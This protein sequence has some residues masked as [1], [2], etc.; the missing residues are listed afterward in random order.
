MDLPL[1]P[2]EL[3]LRFGGLAL[4]HAALI[5]SDLAEGELIC[6][7]AIVTKDDRR[8]VIPFEAESQVEAI[9]RGKASLEELRDQIDFWSLGREG[10]WSDSDSTSGKVDVLVISAWTHG[11]DA[12]ITLMQRFRPAAT[13]NFSLLGSVDIILEGTILSDDRAATLRTLVSEGIAQHPNDVPWS[14]WLLH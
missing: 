5:A 7:F 3:A 11:M 13:G 4:A 2:T 6:P 8:Q 10:L 1:P 12:P 14:S 9:E